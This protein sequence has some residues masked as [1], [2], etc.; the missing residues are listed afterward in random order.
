MTEFTIQETFREIS[1]FQGF[2]TNEC[3]ELY[4][5]SNKTERTQAGMDDHRFTRAALQTF[6]NNLCIV[7]AAGS[8]KTYLMRQFLADLP[9]KERAATLVVA[10]TGRAADNPESIPSYRPSLTVAARSSAAG[11]CQW[12]LRWQSE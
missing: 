5:L 6:S 11:R 2:K 4:V 7:G 9:P 8:G 1:E 12:R 3:E 10:P